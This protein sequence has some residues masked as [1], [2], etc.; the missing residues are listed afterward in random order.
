MNEEKLKIYWSA[1][2]DAWKLFKQISQKKN[3]EEF[4]ASINKD[5]LAMVKK[6]NDSEFAK[7]LFID[8]TLMAMN[9]ISKR[10]NVYGCNKR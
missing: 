4:W 6:Y 3:D 10:E 2:A 1:Y 7:R 9:N 8:T 5:A